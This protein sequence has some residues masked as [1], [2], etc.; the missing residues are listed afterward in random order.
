PREAKMFPGQEQIYW[1][2]R[3]GRRTQRWERSFA[4]S[5]AGRGP[6]SLAERFASTFR[7][8]RMPG[9]IVLTSGLF[10]MKRRAISAIE[11]P[12]GTSGL[13]ASACSTL[14]LRLSGTK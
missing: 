3:V 1:L 13:S 2:Q 5:S 10:R 4:W 7:I 14:D 9:M 6:L 11:E 8:L 12:A